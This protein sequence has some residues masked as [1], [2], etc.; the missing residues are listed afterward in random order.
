[1]VG[2]YRATEPVGGGPVSPSKDETV[3][4][5]LTLVTDTGPRRPR[6]RDQFD[7][8]SEALDAAGL[9]DPESLVGCP[10]PTFKIMAEHGEILAELW[11]HPDGSHW[12]ATQFVSGVTQ[13]TVSGP[14]VDLAELVAG[15]TR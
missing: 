7:E 15:W 8:V 12:C 13:G 10:F 14:L 6:P 9:A 1:M 2:P 4:E 3:A 5:I 11:Q